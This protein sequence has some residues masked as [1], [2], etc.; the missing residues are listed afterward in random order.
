[1]QEWRLYSRML[2]NSGKFSKHKNFGYPETVSL[3]S[4]HGT[5][6]SPGKHNTTFIKNHT[7]PI[8]NWYSYVEGF[9]W[10]FV[11]KTLKEF[12]AD[13]NTIVL[14]P[15]C[16]SG[17]TLV[18][19]SL[20]G[21]KSIGNDINPFLTFVSRIK[22]NF[23]LSPKKGFSELSKISRKF[24]AYT[25]S[26]VN[27]ISEIGLSEIF[28]THTFFSPNILPKVL[29]VKQCINE[30]PDR[31]IRNLFTLAMCSILVDVSNYRRGPDLATKKA[32][33]T[34]YLVFERFLEKASSMLGDFSF[35]ST[36]TS[37]SQII[38]EDSRKLTKIK[39]NSVDL[40]ITS[41]PYLN[42]TNYFRNTKLELWYINE[43]SS[44]EDLHNFREKAITAGINDA[45]KSKYLEST[46]PNVQ[47]ILRKINLCTY[48]S[49]IPLMISTYF[50]E[51]SLCFERL[52]N[53]MRA[54]GRCYW[55]VGDSAFSKII[56]PTDRITT[57]IAM[58]KGFS[59]VDTR[60]VRGRKSRSGLILH[61]AVIV[62]K[63]D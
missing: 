6:N 55:V 61:E 54:T 53:I 62:L 46:I 30:I 59:H 24:S 49:R 40:V 26:S 8:H 50:E 1:M 44:K 45:F 19:S 17:T 12:K 42:G 10:D 60:I 14:D 27:N 9:S 16:G 52:Y 29:F 38:N 23:S 25:K 21:I 57:E 31:K 5:P 33:L 3:I 43:I 36:K 22:T 7:T 39:N 56:I 13:P 11:Q 41:P 34:D 18:E 35:V 28:A 48:D 2:I 20:N 15:F 4:K 63:K 58:K 37:K 51:I 47:K 32:P